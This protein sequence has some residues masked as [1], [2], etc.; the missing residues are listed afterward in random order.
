MKWSSNRK[1]SHQRHVPDRYRRR[2]EVELLENR[3][4]P[5]AASGNLWPHPELITLSF[6]PDGTNLGGPTSNLFA[7]FNAAFGSASAWQNQILKA[8]QAW[9]QQTNLN[10]TV[11]SDNG[12]GSGGGAYQQ[13]DPAMG[14][15]RIGGFNFN[16][17]GI[18]ALAYMPPA[19]NNYSIAGDIAFNTGKVFNVNGLDY[20][21]FTVAAHEL[22]HALGL[23]HSNQSAARMYSTYDG[24][25]ATLEPDDVAGI[26]SIYRG[27]RAPDPYDTAAANG[28]FATATDL[29]P[30]IDAQTLTAA[31]SGLDITSTA[32]VDFYRFTAPS[33]GNGQVTVTVRSSGFSLL[34][35]SL[36]AYNA[37]Q[38]QVG[39]ATGSGYLGSTLT[40]TFAV[41]PGQTYYLRVAGANTTAFGTGAYGLTLKFGANSPALSPRATQVAN[42]NPTNGG[43]GVA[44]RRDAN[45]VSVQTLI[46]LLGDTGNL[47]GGLLGGVLELPFVSVQTTGDGRFEPRARGPARGPTLLGLSALEAPRPTAQAPR[48]ETVLWSAPSTGL[49]PALP[50]PGGPS[51]LDE[52]CNRACHVGNTREEGTWTDLDELEGDEARDLIFRTWGFGTIDC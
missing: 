31:V 11:V 36:K 20:D 8:A 44:N 43:G 37:N 38:S 45:G 52:T 17:S 49:F 13:G 29:T 30:R 22:G 28:S 21:L 50:S 23:N 10:F 26:R 12:T 2:L 39:T 40:T 1:K 41:A 42:A 24:V 51:A 46:D 4:V 35:P 32:D 33:G 7:R 25:E 48:L 47:L 14:D 9:A 27:S 15:I 5:Y 34:A 19:V 18:L 16:N 6:Q 3:T